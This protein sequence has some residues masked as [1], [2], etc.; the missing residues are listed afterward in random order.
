MSEAKG[1]AE[2]LRSA[3]ELSEFKYNDELIG[4]TASFGVVEINGAD[5]LIEEAID[6]ADLGLYQA[7]QTGRNCVV[8]VRS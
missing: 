7:K 5:T 4:V 8:E 6:K 3:L 1:V 2:R